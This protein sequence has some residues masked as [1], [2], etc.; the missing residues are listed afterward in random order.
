MNSERIPSQI[1]YGQNPMTRNH[2]HGEITLFETTQ[3]LKYFGMNL[4]HGTRTLRAVTNWA[5]WGIYPLRAQKLA[6]FRLLFNT[7]VLILCRQMLFAAV[8][9]PGGRTPWRSDGDRT[10][11]MSIWPFLRLTA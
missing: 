4:P 5:I 9:R 6:G 7:L 8:V 10:A 3:T 1:E 11:H 2:G